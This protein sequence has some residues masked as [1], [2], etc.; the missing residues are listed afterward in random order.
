[1]SI[2]KKL[3]T[4]QIAILFFVIFLVGMASVYLFIKYNEPEPFSAVVLPEISDEA[5][6][7]CDGEKVQNLI[8]TREEGELGKCFQDFSGKEAFFEDISKCRIITDVLTSETDEGYWMSF[9]CARSGDVLSPYFGYVKKGEK[10][11]SWGVLPQG[12]ILSEESNEDEKSITVEN[13]SEIPWILSDPWRN[14]AGKE[15]RTSSPENEE[16]IGL[17]KTSI[18]TVPQEDDEYYFENA[19]HGYYI[20]IRK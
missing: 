13:I 7:T 11:I 14:S 12:K 5:S 18:F 17:H 16:V 2:Q 8:E 3:S 15:I 6:D 9:K 20:E 10:S 19:R 4:P 1:M